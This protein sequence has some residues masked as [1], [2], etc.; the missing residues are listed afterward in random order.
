MVTTTN[1]TYIT[2]ILANTQNELQRVRPEMPKRMKESINVTSSDKEE[3]VRLKVAWQAWHQNKERCPKGSVPIRRSHVHDVLR[4]NSL[5][6]FG[7]KRRHAF[8][9]T[10]LAMAGRHPDAPDVVSANGHE[11][12]HFLL[13][14]AIFYSY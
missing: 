1:Y 6:D 14:S 4:A 7:K 3:R 8:S 13:T 11:V 9:G 10:R 2:L 12:I 5:Y